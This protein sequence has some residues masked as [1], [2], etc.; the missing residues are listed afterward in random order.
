MILR[1]IAER[2]DSFHLSTVDENKYKKGAIT[3]CKIDNKEKRKDEDEEE[4][5]HLLF[6]FIVYMCAF[7]RKNLSCSF[8]LLL[9]TTHTD[10]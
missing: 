9:L 3:E 6:S 10:I 7:F 8:N 1:S 2:N 4:K 5:I